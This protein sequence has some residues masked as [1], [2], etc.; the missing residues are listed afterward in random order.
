[1]L[2]LILMQEMVKKMEVHKFWGNFVKKYEIEKSGS[3]LIEDYVVNKK[4][5]FKAKIRICSLG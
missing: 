4:L 5:S 1:M 3:Q 2:R